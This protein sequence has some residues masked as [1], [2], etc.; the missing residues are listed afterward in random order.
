MRETKSR[1]RRHEEGDKAVVV[2]DEDDHELL[3]DRV[4]PP[5]AAMPNF[6]SYCPGWTARRKDA[7]QRRRADKREPEAPESGQPG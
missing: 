6:R 1:P 2:G 4:G 3:L 5:T 7:G